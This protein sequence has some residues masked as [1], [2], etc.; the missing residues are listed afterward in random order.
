[1]SAPILSG[2]LN[3]P[4]GTSTTIGICSS[5]SST[6]NTNEA[7]N[8]N[9]TNASGYSKTGISEVNG[10]VNAAVSL[11]AAGSANPVCAATV[12]QTLSVRLGTK[13]DGDSSTQICQ[14]KSAGDVDIN[15]VNNNGNNNGTA[16][17]RSPPFLSSLP[18]SRNDAQFMSLN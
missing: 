16:G 14:G 7:S 4:I 8:S 17:S 1:M 18:S 9:T 13:A 5:N 10:A 3:G 15:N 2:P 12:Q 6:S 11:A